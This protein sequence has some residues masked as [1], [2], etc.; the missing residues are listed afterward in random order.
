MHWEIEKKDPF[1]Q[2]ETSKSS[3]KDLLKTC[4]RYQITL[5]IMLKKYKPNGEIEFRPVCFNLTTKTVINHRFTHK[6]VFQEILYRVDN[7][8]NEGCG[9]IVELMEPQYIN[10]WTYRPLPGGSY[11]KLPFEFKSPEKVL[12]KI[13]NNDQKCFLW[14]HVRHINCVKIHPE[15]TTGEEKKLAN[16]LDYDRVEFPLRV[17]DFIKIEK[18]NNICINVFCYENRLTFPIYVSDQKLENSMSI[19]L[20][21]WVYK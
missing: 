20:V 1:K 7:C 3:I 18:K 21:L 5:K 9:W 6:N 8:I 2:L 13:K 17:K 16:D 14:C 10:I 12:T 15:R 19:S 4:F 11:V